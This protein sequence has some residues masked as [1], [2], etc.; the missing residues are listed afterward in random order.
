M[1]AR[2]RLTAAWIASFVVGAGLLFAFE[3]TVTRVIGV[4][5]LFA[6]VILGTFLIAS[7]EALAESPEDHEPGL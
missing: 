7:P 2:R 3:F 4:A 5:G 1:N 6:F